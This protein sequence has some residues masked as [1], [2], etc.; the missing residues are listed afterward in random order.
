MAPEIYEAKEQARL[1]ALARKV[2]EWQKL[3]SLSDT[4]LAKKVP[5]IGSTKTYKKILD[6]DFSEMDVEG[7]LSEYEA[8]VAWTESL[9]ADD[10]DEEDWDEDMSGAVA[11]RAAFNRMR[12]TTGIARCG[13]VIG[14]T[15][16]GKSGSRTVLMRKFG[17]SLIQVSANVVWKDKPVALLRA[18]AHAMGMKNIP[19]YGVEL[20]EKVHEK[21]N[22][23]TIC[24]QIEE[25]H[26]LGPNCLDLIK[27]LINDTLASFVIYAVD[28]LWNRMERA[29]YEQARQLTGNRF[30]FKIIFDDGMLQ[31][32]IDRMVSR[33]AKLDAGVYDK[34]AK[35]GLLNHAR[36]HGR[37]AF[38]REFLK[39]LHRRTEGKPA[40]KGD[41]I[42]TVAAEADARKKQTQEVAK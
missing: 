33:R 8:A 4:Q 11:L 22:E 18:I 32:D 42:A 29:A 25:G 2:E 17:A 24:V 34:D 15:G 21:L 16:S 10:K 35:A 6:E 28:T 31:R 36:S 37:L 20:Y 5:Q 9:V 38:V 30:A 3:N 40:D 7:Q 27:A 19:S 13:F 39:K 26:H 14:P 12:S 1:L 41:W 23:K